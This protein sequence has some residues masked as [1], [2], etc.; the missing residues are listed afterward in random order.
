MIKSK[1]LTSGASLTKNSQFQEISSIFTKNHFFFA[2]WTSLIYQ[3]ITNFCTW[4]CSRTWLIK[5]NFLIYWYKPSKGFH[6]TNTFNTSCSIINFSIWFAN[7]TFFKGILVSKPIH[8]NNQKSAT[9]TFLIQSSITSILFNNIFLSL[10]QSKAQ[11]FTN[12][13]ND[14][15]LITLEHLFKKSSKLLNSQFF[16]LSCCINSHT[17]SHIHL[18]EMNQSLI[19]SPIAATWL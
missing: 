10:K 19:S 1:F 11:D 18:T 12:H 15:L 17:S 8:Q 4:S 9:Q 2:L 7:S 3:I 5:E 14:F 16:C 6:D 13:S